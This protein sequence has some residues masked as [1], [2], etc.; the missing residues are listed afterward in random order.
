MAVGKVSQA[1]TT[2][3]SRTRQTGS[4]GL[5]EFGLIIDGKPHPKERPRV[6][7]AT[8]VVYTPQRSQEAEKQ[9]AAAW[10]AKKG[11]LFP[12]GTKLKLSMFFT[13]DGTSLVVTPLEYEDRVS[14]RGDIDNYVKTVMDGLNGVAWEDD[15][16]VVQ[17]E[18]SKA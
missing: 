3:R 16:Q 13:E 1:R 8:G 7:K 4:A 17:I 10:T 9:I 6:V 14:I 12:K 15:V 18:A 11:P 2:G 5:R